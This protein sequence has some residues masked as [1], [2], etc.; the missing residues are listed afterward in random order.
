MLCS[1]RLIL[2]SLHRR[3]QQIKHQLH[4]AL[5]FTAI[6]YHLHCTLPD[7]WPLI[8][9]NAGFHLALLPKQS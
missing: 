8:Y 4:K 6:A 9:D 3:Y 7:L 5:I 2:V 1:L